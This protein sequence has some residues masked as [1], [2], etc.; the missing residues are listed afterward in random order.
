MVSIISPVIGWILTIAGY[1]SAAITLSFI[2]FTFEKA[3]HTFSNQFASPTTKKK[4]NCD[5]GQSLAPSPSQNNNNARPYPPN[6]SDE[7]G[8]KEDVNSVDKDTIYPASSS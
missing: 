7:D 8:P 5:N 2:M 6:L 1:Y 4:R 3:M